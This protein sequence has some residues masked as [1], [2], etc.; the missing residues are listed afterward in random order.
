MN[1]CSKC[2]N[3]MNFTIKPKGPHVG[4]YCEQC[5]A[6]I[7]WLKQN[8]EPNTYPVPQYHQITLDEYAA[9]LNKDPRDVAEEDDL[10]WR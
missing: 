9:S 7:C 3:D 5:G 6:W 2:G 10:P 1:K 8:K 4:L